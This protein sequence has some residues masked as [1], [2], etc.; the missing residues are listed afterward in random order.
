MSST[1]NATNPNNATG[2]VTSRHDDKVVARSF[3]K[4]EHRGPPACRR[5]ALR[6]GGKTAIPRQD[7]ENTTGR[8]RGKVERMRWGGW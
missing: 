4:R 6:N 2:D 5:S 8:Q 3:A 7:G 1:A